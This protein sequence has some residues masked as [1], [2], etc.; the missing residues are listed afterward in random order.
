MRTHI[1]AGIAKP[2]SAM[3][4]WGIALLALFIFGAILFVG[5]ANDEPTAPAL[6]VPDEAQSM[7]ELEQLL[8]KHNGGAAELAKKG[9][10]VELPG[11]SN[12]ALA[13]AIAAA[14]KNGTVKVKAG[15]H[16]ESQTVTITQR[17]KII[18]ESGAVFEFDTQPLPPASEVEP[19]LH[20]KNADDVVIWGVEIRP[21]SSVGGTAILV[22]DSE[23]AIIGR[24]TIRD[25]QFS[26]MLEGGDEAEI[27]KNTMLASTGWQTGNPPEVHG[28]VVINGKKVE[29]EK[30]DISN[31][32][33]GVWACDEKGEAERNTFHGNFIGL[34]LCKVPANAFPLPGGK[35]AGS[36]LSAVAWKIEDNHSTGNFNA[37]YLVIDGA[38]NNRL[39]NN[40]A[41]NNGTYD[42]ELA[43]DSFRFGFLTPKSFDNKVVAGKYKNILIKD[44]GENNK[45]VGGQLVDN[46]VDLCN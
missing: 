44:C 20:I 30:N 38:N 11:G 41:S 36:A 39:K 8:A 23:D 29:I 16:T 7:A 35:L 3:T 2:A 12:D 45:V 21:K 10:T 26:V 34:I 43:G 32:F 28:I 4:R 27:Y 9:K 13:A 33:F 22:E 24:N 19:G 5:C 46:S 18:G 40:N 1:P 42:I 14:G 17:V 31:A 6:V 25:H 37:G 15:S